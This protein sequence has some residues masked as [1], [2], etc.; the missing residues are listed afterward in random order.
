MGPI[1]L[2]PGRAVEGRAPCLW[3]FSSGA[4]PPFIASRDPR[5]IS[6]VTPGV[7]DM[8]HRLALLVAS[9]VASLTLAAGLVIAGFV[10]GAHPAD[11][12]QVAPAAAVDAAPTP[13]IQVDTVYVAP[14]VAPQDVTVTKVVRSQ[15]G[16][17]DGEGGGDD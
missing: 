16:D 1:V 10:P 7:L 3:T 13:R 15:G 6:S 14:Q 8:V 17:D 5:D 4:H 11:A 12:G 2:P 9:L